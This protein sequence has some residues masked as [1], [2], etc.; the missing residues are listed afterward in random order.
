MAEHINT[1]VQPVEQVRLGAVKAAIWRNEGENG[2]RFNVTFERLYRN[3]QGQ[4]RS[5]FSFGQGDLLLLAKVADGAHT[6]IQRM[7]AES[8]P[9]QPRRRGAA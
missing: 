3:E 6:R 9:P 4:W 2:P 8:K 1:K 5:T 7:I